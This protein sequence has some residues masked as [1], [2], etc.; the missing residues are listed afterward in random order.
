VVRTPLTHNP[1]NGVT[2]DLWSED[3]VVHKVLTRH[4]DAPLH[5]TASD[6]E[7]HWNYWPR[8]ALAYESD[9]PGR[10]GLGAPRLLGIE[11]TERGELELL[12]EHVDG[13]HGDALGDADL[14]A[15]ARELGRA[16]GRDELPDEEWL[17]RGFL[18]A[19]GDGRPVDWGL[20]D[21]DAAW[22]RPLIREHFSAGLRAALS[23]LHESR[24]RLLSLSEG[25]PR[26]LCHLDVW[27]GNVIRRPG[28]E[29]VFLDWA[30]AGDGAIGEDAGNLILNAAG[31][32]LALDELD[33]GVTAAYLGGLREAGWRGDER[34]ARLGICATAVRYD[35]LTPYC[36]EHAENAE[37]EPRLGGF[38]AALTLC[39]RW[40]DET[41]RP[42]AGRA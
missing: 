3:E 22:S 7:R 2:A 18:R 19:F 26:T 20:V 14:E 10:L 24:E 6:D 8:E 27:Q 31:P 1:A 38:A 12:L 41:E 4:G 23:R 9:L 42:G 21:D 33:A 34:V 30:F 36:L 29:I 16:Q 35:W 17:S 32:G 13:R 37:A 39:A 11:E 5:W 40:A 15:A 28:G 25:L